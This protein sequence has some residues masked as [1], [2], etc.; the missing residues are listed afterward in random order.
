MDIITIKYDSDGNEKWVNIFNGT[1]NSYD[2]GTTIAVDDSGNCYVGGYAENSGAQQDFILLKYNS[3]RNELW[4][5]IYSGT[6][7]GNDVVLSMT[8]DDSSFIYLTGRSVGVEQSDD[9]TTIKYNSSGEQRWVARYNDSAVNWGE[10]PRSINGLRILGMC[11]S[12]VGEP[13]NALGDI[14]TIKYNSNGIQQWIKRYYGPSAGGEGAYSIALD[15]LGNVYVGGSVNGPYWGQG[16]SDADFTTVKYDTDGN[17]LWVATYNGPATEANWDWILA[18]KVTLSGDVYVTGWS[19]GLNTGLDVVTIAYDSAGNQQWLERYDGGIGSSDQAYAMAV[20][21]QGNIYVAGFGVLDPSFTS[22]MLTIKYSPEPVSVQQTN[23]DIPDN[24][25]LMQ[26]YP[27]PFNPS[28]RIQF[29]IPSIIASETKQ[30]QL[31]TLKIYDVLG[32]EVSTLVNEEKPAGSYEVEFNALDLSSGIYFYKLQAGSF[33]E[34][35]KM[36]LLK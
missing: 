30:A 34:T 8:M 22:D 17:E 11:M 18:M 23:S 7:S 2:G 19:E 15:D 4:H 13:M 20:D 6:G 24:F 1:S 36:T 26:N 21:L 31:V 14:L 27:N 32:N 5:Q 28:T 25:L 16:E 35:K 9:Y 3:S 12:V 33:I 29:S 10:T